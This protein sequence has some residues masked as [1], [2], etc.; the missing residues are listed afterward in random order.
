MIYPYGESLRLPHACEEMAREV[1]DPASRIWYLPWAREYLIDRFS[2]GFTVLYCCPFCGTALPES[3][4]DEYWDRSDAESTP[5]WGAGGDS[6][7]RLE[8]G[9][10]VPLTTVDPDPPVRI[11]R[12]L[13]MSEELLVANMVEGL[14]GEVR[15]GSMKSG[16]RVSVDVRGAVLELLD[17]PAVEAE[18]T[19]VSRPSEIMVVLGIAQ[20]CVTRVEFVYPPAEWWHEAID[21]QTWDKVGGLSDSS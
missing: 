2:G 12:S 1:V 8:P 21:R 18:F 7:W 15:A 3:L 13:T 6:W 5:G 20:D 11:R 4:R 16:A 9:L 10:T 19:L 14:N 17:S